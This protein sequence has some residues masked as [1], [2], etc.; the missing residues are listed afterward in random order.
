MNGSDY[1][2]DDETKSYYVSSQSNW[3]YSCSGTFAS[4]TSNSSDYV[5]NTT[6]EISNDLYVTAHICPVSLKYYGFCLR[7][8]KYVV[9]LHFAEICRF[10]IANTF[11][12]LLDDRVLENFNPKAAI[13]TAKKEVIRSFNA[14]VKQDHMLRI[15]LYWAGKGSLPANEPLIS[16]I[17]VT[18]GMKSPQ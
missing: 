17:S 16:A 7:Q 12:E 6:Y 10:T 3:A 5:K 13:G 9:T 1:V 8:G 11:K 15:H 18:P 14:S 2:G 4:V